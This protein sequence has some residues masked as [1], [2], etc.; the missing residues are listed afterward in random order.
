MNPN[1]I[2]FVIAC[3]P[4]TEQTPERK[5]DGKAEEKQDALLL[6]CLNQ[7]ERAGKAQRKTRNSHRGHR[8][9]DSAATR[10]LKE[11]CRQMNGL[12]E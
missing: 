3:A 5:L 2:P 6:Q 7:V 12:Q 4:Q 1:L 8:H 9:T 11:V 10:R